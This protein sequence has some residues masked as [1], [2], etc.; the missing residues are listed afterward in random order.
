MTE[1][2][3][4]RAA[5]EPLWRNH[6]PDGLTED[7]IAALQE[8]VDAELRRAGYPV[9][10]PQPRRRPAPARPRKEGRRAPRGRRTS[11]TKRGPGRNADRRRD[12]R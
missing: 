9:R 7:A 2:W 4:V 8:E 10:S 6:Y 11:P 5:D 12:E 1:P 3:N